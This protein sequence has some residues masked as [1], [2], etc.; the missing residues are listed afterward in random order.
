MKSSISYAI[1]CEDFK[2]LKRT[3][4]RVMVASLT[5]LALLLLAVL[6]YFMTYSESI[7]VKESL[8]VT[9]S[10]DHHNVNVSI[11]ELLSLVGESAALPPHAPVNKSCVPEV[12]PR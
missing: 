1:P 12:L 8:I 6:A 5:S 9:R 3:D 10:S 11:R 4:T 7:Q 2:M